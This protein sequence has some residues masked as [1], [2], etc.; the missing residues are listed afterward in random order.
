MERACERWGERAEG[1]GRESEV[2]LKSGLGTGGPCAGYE[3]G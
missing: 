1:L 2:N 3:A